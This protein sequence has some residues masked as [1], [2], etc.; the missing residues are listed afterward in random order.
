MKGMNPW[1]NE[2]MKDM[3]SWWLRPKHAANANSMFECAGKYSSSVHL[4]IQRLCTSFTSHHLLSHDSTEARSRKIREDIEISKLSSSQKASY[5]NHKLSSPS[6]DSGVGREGNLRGYDEEMKGR[7]WLETIQW[8]NEG[9]NLSFWDPLVRYIKYPTNP[10]NPFSERRSVASPS[11]AQKAPHILPRSYY[12]RIH[13]STP[14]PPHL[15]QSKEP[16]GRW[17]LNDDEYSMKAKTRYRI[18]GKEIGDF[19]P[20]SIA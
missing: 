20:I 17:T 16:K 11:L 18:S 1:E 12:Y 7:R 3:K 10:Q 15:L 2:E 9:M 13:L 8:E 14:D 19:R 6:F 5:P 4:A